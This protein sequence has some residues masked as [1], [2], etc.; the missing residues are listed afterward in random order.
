MVRRYAEVG[1]YAI[2]LLHA[3]QTQCRAQKAEVALHVVEALVI[4]GIGLR[5]A[6]LVE[7]VEATLST[8]LLQDAAG[9]TA[10]TKGEVGIYAIGFDVEQVDA[11]FQEY[12][13]VIR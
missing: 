13:N 2:Y 9:V 11:L 1:E 4:R 6:I 3:S 10:S 5:V 8:Q 12:G 7:A